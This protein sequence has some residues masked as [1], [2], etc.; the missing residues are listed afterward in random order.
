[1][2]YTKLGYVGSKL[3][4]SGA[5]LLFKDRLLKEDGLGTA[6]DEFTIL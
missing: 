4:T 1:M 3:T 5:T 2:E 6:I